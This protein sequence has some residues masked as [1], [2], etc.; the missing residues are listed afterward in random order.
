MFSL[1]RFY[2]NIKHLG[3]ALF[4]LIFFIFFIKFNI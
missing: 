3:S 2:P 4:C 1:D